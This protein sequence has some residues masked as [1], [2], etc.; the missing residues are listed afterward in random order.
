MKDNFNVY[1]W[2]K[3]RRK[4]ILNE[5]T[6]VEL[7]NIPDQV[8]TKF[9][10]QIRNPQT[11]A[12]A[13]LKLVDKLGEKENQAIMNNPKLDRA[14]DLLR[15]LSGEKQEKEVNEAFKP[16]KLKKVTVGGKTYEKG[17]LDPD[18]DGKILRIEKFPNGYFITASTGREGYGYAIDLKGNEIDEDDLEGMEDYYNENKIT[19]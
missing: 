7:P 13:V 11:F 5:S 19:K 15:Q 12:S 6:E 3:I 1:K 16:K 2:N 8:F 17:E 14:M 9:A 4:N 10:T 18:D